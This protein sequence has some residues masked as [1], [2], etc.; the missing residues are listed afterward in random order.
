MVYAVDTN[1]PTGLVKDS[2]TVLNGATIYYKGERSLRYCKYLI[3]EEESIDMLYKDAKCMNS[4]N[5]TPAL[6]S[7]LDL[8]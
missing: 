4:S 1:S 8:K 3:T 7:A 5:P 6:L 2:L